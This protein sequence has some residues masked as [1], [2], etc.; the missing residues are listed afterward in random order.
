[1]QCILAFIK[2]ILSTN[3]KDGVAVDGDDEH[4]KGGWSPPE[5]IL[6]VFSPPNFSGDNLLSLCFF[7]FDLRAAMLWERP[8]EHF[9]SRF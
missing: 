8:G 9:Y 1:M 7:I 3:R 5:A 4:A 6:A 2:F